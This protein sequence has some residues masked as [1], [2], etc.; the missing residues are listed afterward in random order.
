[1]CLFFRYEEPKYEGPPGYNS[2]SGQAALDQLPASLEFKD[3][4]K[5]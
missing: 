3:R 5:W 4:S 2:I 1:M